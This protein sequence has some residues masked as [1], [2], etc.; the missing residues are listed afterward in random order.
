MIPLLLSLGSWSFGFISTCLIVVLPLQYICMPYLPE[1]FFKTFS[2]SL[3][4][5][6]NHISYTG[7]LPCRGAASVLAP[8]LWVSCE[9]IGANPWCGGLLLCL[10]WG[11]GCLVY[12]CLLGCCCDWCCPPSCCWYIYF[13]PCWWPS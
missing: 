13:V 2:Y 4:V 5:G 1:I 10:C 8:Q 3:G 6:D 7:F 11:C 12:C 9:E